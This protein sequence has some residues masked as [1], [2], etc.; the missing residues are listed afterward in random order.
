LRIAVLAA[1]GPSESG[2]GE[3]VSSMGGA[4]RRIGRAAAVRRNVRR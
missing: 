2:G 4:S 1:G 3:L